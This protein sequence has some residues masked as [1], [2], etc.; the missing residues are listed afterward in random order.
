MG[1]ELNSLWALVLP[2]FD[3]N[4]R[5]FLSRTK[6]LRERKKFPP[7]GLVTKQ[8]TFA[9][10]LHY[11]YVASLPLDYSGLPAQDAELEGNTDLTVIITMI[12]VFQ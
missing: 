7:R 11:H 6:K 12:Q 3:A 1:A 8:E 10:N 2:R 4:S 5:N 9:G